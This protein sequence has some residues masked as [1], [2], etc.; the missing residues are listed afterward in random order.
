[1]GL[2]TFSNMS[3]FA[4]TWSM[5]NEKRILAYR[6]LPNEN[7]YLR[8]SQ[9]AEQVLENVKAGQSITTEKEFDSAEFYKRLLVIWGTKLFIGTHRIDHVSIAVKNREKAVH[10]IKNILG[11]IPG[12]DLSDENMKYRWEM[13]SIGDLSRRL[14]YRYRSHTE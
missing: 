12:A 9:F 6:H 7:T 2:D 10:F 11:A 14:P 4:P 5:G 8:V 3:T 13:F 1:M